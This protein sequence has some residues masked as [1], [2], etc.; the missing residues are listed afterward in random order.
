MPISLVSLRL[1]A[2]G[3]TKLTNFGDDTADNQLLLAGGLDGRAELGIVP[4]VDLA[5]AMDNGHIGV[6][7]HDLLD[8]QSVG[9]SI[10]GS[11]HDNG[12]I[13]QVAQ[14]GVGKHV[15]AEVVGV[16][17]ADQLGETDLV[18]NDE[19][20]LVGKLVAERPGIGQKEIPR[21]PCPVDSSPWRSRRP[22]GEQ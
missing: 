12:Q 4:G 21:S 7:I 14:G 22:P 2:G 20:G 18:V 6:Q 15:V 5:L 3:K 17:V 13:E 16:E 1:D 8:H 9:T 19:N 10:R 11:G